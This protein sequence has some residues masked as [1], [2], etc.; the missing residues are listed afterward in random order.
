M[1]YTDFFLK[2]QIEICISV[3]EKTEKKY[4]FKIR[5]LLEILKVKSYLK[6]FKRLNSIFQTKY[7]NSKTNNITNIL[8]KLAS[9]VVILNNI[10]GF[11]EKHLNLTLKGE[12]L[13]ALYISKEEI[14]FEEIAITLIFMNKFEE[15]SYV[16]KN[17]IKNFDRIQHIKLLTIL[18]QHKNGNF[19][20]RNILYSKYI[21]PKTELNDLGDRILIIRGLFGFEFWQGYNNYPFPDY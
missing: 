6:D 15:V 3:F 20:E 19:K 17:H 14:E 7:Q 10:K 13:N 9:D 4:D 21:F 11:N 16:L 2:E 5:E 1:N 18:Q 12:F 8:E